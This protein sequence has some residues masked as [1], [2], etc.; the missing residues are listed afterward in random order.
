MSVGES[1]KGVKYLFSYTGPDGSRQHRELKEKVLFLSRSGMV[2][3]EQIRILLFLH[4]HLGICPGELTVAIDPRLQTCA[5]ML[6][7]NLFA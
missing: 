6:Y 3:Q 4:E 1:T 5:M 7:M 2:S